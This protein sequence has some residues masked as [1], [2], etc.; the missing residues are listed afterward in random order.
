[1]INRVRVICQQV[2]SRVGIGFLDQALASGTAFIIVIVAARWLGVARFGQLSLLL[3]LVQF[4]TDLQNSYMMMPYVARLHRLPVSDQAAY[5]RK[6]LWGCVG[7]TV[8]LAIAISIFVWVSGFLIPR[9]NIGDLWLGAGLLALGRMLQ[10]AWRRDA[11]ARYQAKQ[12]LV[13][14]ILGYGS[15]AIFLMAAAWLTQSDPEQEIWFFIVAL[16]GAGGVIAGTLMIL[17]RRHQYGG[18]ALEKDQGSLGDTGDTTYVEPI[19]RQHWPAG[20]WLVATVGVQY[21]STNYLMLSGAAV[22]GPS[23]AGALRAMQG[24]MGVIGLMFQALDLILPVEMGRLWHQQGAQALKNFMFRVGSGLMLVSLVLAMG[25]VTVTP[26][27]LPWL[28]GE[29][30]AGLTAA[31]ALMGSVYVMLAP[32]LLM[33]YGFRTVEVTRPIFVS[34]FVTAVFS[35]LTAAWWI[36]T[37]GMMGVIGG[38]AAAQAIMLGWYL[39]VWLFRPPI[40]EGCDV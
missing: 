38:M 14:D 28:F 27:L 3:L 25:I 26:W 22:L 40:S 9:W 35:L 29:E 5:R 17:S 7:V 21:L 20:K 36:D 16:A 2:L 34:Y 10:D 33:R 31:M 19:F 12:S 24:V 23:M 8:L 15:M 30:Y 18:T 6:V 13:A 37:W 4:C 1:M 39:G 32:V 11:Y